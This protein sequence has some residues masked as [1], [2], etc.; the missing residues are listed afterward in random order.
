MTMLHASNNKL[1]QFY[2]QPFKFNPILFK[3]K[4]NIEIGGLF[5]ISSSLKNE[6]ITM[7]DKIVL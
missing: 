7:T 5:I 3:Y 4:G 1:T 6:N 2:L